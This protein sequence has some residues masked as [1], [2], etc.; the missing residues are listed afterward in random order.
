MEIKLFKEEF[1]KKS[2]LYPFFIGEQ[3]DEEH[4]S[5]KIIEISSAPYF[6]IY[7][8]RSHQSKERFI[9]A[10]QTIQKHYLSL[11]REVL[12]NRTF[13]Y[14]LLLT[15][16]KEDILNDYPELIESDK[17]FKNIVLKKFDWENYIYKAILTA[18]YVTQIKPEDEWDFYYAWVYENLDI[19]N[20]MIKY[21]VFRNSNFILAILDLT[22]ELEVSDIMKKKIRHLELPGSDERVGRRVIYEFNKSYPVLLSPMLTKE[23]LKPYFIDYL[24]MYALPED[25]LHISF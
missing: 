20:Y 3:I 5:N 10:C 23:E 22:R 16:F 7:L 1:F 24:K 19:F 25:V 21:E 4:F 6:P 13:W 18:Q 14:T 8:G 17:E 2:T 9:E 11:D 15:E 12:L